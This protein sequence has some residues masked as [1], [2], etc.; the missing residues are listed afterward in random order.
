MHLVFWWRNFRKG[1]RLKDVDIDGTTLALTWFPK[2]RLVKCR[3]DYRDSVKDKSTALLN[4]IM[5]FWV[6]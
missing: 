5:D 2:N 4:L 1:F 3:L 6:P